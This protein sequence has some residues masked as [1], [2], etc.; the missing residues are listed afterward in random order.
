MP[1]AQRSAQRQVRNLH[2]RILISVQGTLKTPY[3]GQIRTYLKPS[4]NGTS[5]REVQIGYDLGMKPLRA[6]TRLLV[7]GAVFV[8]LGTVQLIW[9]GSDAGMLGLM[10]GGALAALVG[11]YLLLRHGG[12]LR[13]PDPKQ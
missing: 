3:P 5:G 2:L 12:Q 10:T 1:S 11:T 7:G 4:E 9:S 6:G 8:V 13:S